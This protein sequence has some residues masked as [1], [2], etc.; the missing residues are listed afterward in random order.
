MFQGQPTVNPLLKHWTPPSAMK[1]VI[2]QTHQK[3]LL[4][5]FFSV[6]QFLRT[7]WN[8]PSVRW[9]DSIGGMEARFLCLGVTNGHPSH[10]ADQFPASR[11]GC[12]LLQRWALGEQR[13]SPILPVDPAEKWTGFEERLKLLKQKDEHITAYRDNAD[14][15]I[16]VSIPGSTR[17]LVSY[18]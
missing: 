6:L 5:G 7:L 17:N 3:T 16:V 1:S 10:A 2:L 14:Q 8:M 12:V 4:L 9:Y 18:F 13:G 11:A 15:D